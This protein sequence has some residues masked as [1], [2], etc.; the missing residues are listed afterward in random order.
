MTTRYLQLSQQHATGVI[1]SDTLL[2]VASLH[3]KH[4]MVIPDRLTELA[5]PQDCMRD[6]VITNRARLVSFL[7]KFKKDHTVKQVNLV[8]QSDQIKTASVS[9]KPAGEKEI[10]AEAAKLFALPV[11]DIV[12]DFKVLG[13]TDKTTM[14]QITGIVKKVSEEFVSAFKQAGIK[15][16]S[17]EPLGHAIARNILPVD[18][19]GT[20][21]IV[22]IDINSTTLSYVVDGRVS[23]TT[24]YEFSDTAIVGQIKRILSVTTANAEI[25]KR[26][27]GLL[28]RGDRAVFDA[29]S[30]DCAKFAKYINHSYITWKNAHPL[31][32]AL[33]GIYITGAGSTILGLGDYLA[34][35][36]R[37]PVLKANV[38]VNCLSFDEHIPDVE[39]SVAVRYGA[40]IG[41][42]LI[43]PHMVNLVPDAHQ[44]SLRRQYI[45]RRS[46]K[47]FLS[48][49]LGLVAGIIIAW[50]IA[51]PEVHSKI[52]DV[53]HKLQTQ[54]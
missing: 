43:G 41:T 14:V 47:V 35:A 48:F 16:T 31:L 42:A 9:I 7:K 6:G 4:G 3:E 33:D 26:E 8:L 52:L 25:I 12:Y 28:I 49:I 44:R 36:L 24:L 46:G 34:A 23:E 18:S 29:I 51:I 39:Q 37:M 5:V 38:W 22:D 2:R 17:I 10:A 1:L 15:V 32:P 53:L 21:L 40:A 20:V 19:R 54:W 11:K 27:Q 50:I 30:D 13:S 45:A